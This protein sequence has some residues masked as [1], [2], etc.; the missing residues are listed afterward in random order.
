MEDIKPLLD[1]ISYA[2]IAHKGQVRKGGNDIPYIVH[3]IDVAKRVFYFGGD[4]NMQIAG[5]LHDVVEDCAGYNQ[6]HIEEKFGEDVASLVFYMTTSVKGPAPRVQRKALEKELIASMPVRAKIIKAA[7]I[8][9][10]LSTAHKLG[11]FGQKYIEE[12]FALLEVMQDLPPEIYIQLLEA[13]T[14]ARDDLKVPH[15]KTKDI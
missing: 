4:L 9:S 11:D 14:K 5:V 2:V 15:E 7:D 8:M 10:N 3:P 6:Y 13:I 1:A 12:K